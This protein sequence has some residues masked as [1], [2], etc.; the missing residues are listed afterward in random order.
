MGCVIFRLPPPPM[1]THSL[2]HRPS[3]VTPSLGPVLVEDGEVLGY[4]GAGDGD[5][6]L[7]GK[8]CVYRLLTPT[9]LLCIHSRYH[10]VSS[11]T[12][13]RH[14]SLSWD[15][16]M[17]PSFSDT[18]SSNIGTCCCC[19]L[20]TALFAYHMENLPCNILL[21][22]DSRTYFEVYSN[23]N[24]C[25]WYMTTKLNTASI[26]MVQTAHYSAAVR[27]W[28][29]VLYSSWVLWLWVFCRIVISLISGVLSSSAVCDVT[30]PM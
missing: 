5:G 1:R 19:C 2:T 29:W 11:S 30:F 26:T 24:C 9:Y 10:I 12:C 25:A 8:A 18:T 28:C 27:F 21:L 20:T 17:I 13:R 22:L 14:A 16:P 7:H 6:F 23:S 3:L 4:V 15:N